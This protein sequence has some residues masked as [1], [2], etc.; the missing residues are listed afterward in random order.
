[1]KQRCFYRHFSELIPIGMIA[2]KFN[3]SVYDGVS[4]FSRMAD[5]EWPAEGDKPVA[6]EAVATCIK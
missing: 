4:I 6:P 2:R 5:Q 1:M 3:E